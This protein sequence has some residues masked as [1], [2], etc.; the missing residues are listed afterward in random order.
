MMSKRFV[1]LIVLAVCLCPVVS[2]A[3]GTSGSQFLGIG[4]GARAMGMGGAFVSTTG[5]QV[6]ASALAGSHVLPVA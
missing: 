5:V 2:A 1:S 6:S 4:M 3:Q